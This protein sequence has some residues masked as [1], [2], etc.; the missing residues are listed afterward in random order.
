MWTEAGSEINL[1]KFKYGRYF[2]MFCVL[3]LG[4]ME[5]L[6]KKQKNPVRSHNRIPERH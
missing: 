3:L 6:N 2:P 5:N 4:M 1:I